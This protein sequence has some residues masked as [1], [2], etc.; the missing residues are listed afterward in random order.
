MDNPRE[1]I[2]TRL[3]G[4]FQDVFDDDDLQITEDTSAADI[5][6]WDSLMHVTLIVA[7]EKEFKIKLNAAAI[8]NLK[9][10][11][12]LVDILIAQHK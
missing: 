4:V 5:D 9:N 2:R 11:G 1:L 7:T 12:E 10:V 3:N 8:G 6:E